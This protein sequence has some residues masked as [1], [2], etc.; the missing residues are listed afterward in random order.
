MAHILP[1]Y[2]SNLS[3]YSLRSEFFLS[4]WALAELSGGC[5]EGGIEEAHSWGRGRVWGTPAGTLGL[6]A[7]GSGGPDHL[8]DLVVRRRESSIRA[9]GWGFWDG[10]QRLQQET[11]QLILCTVW[12]CPLF[13]TFIHI[14]NKLNEWQRVDSQSRCLFQSCWHWNVDSYKIFRYSN[15]SSPVHKQMTLMNLFFLVNP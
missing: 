1:W 12:Y 5:D 14:L 7:A 4:G 6:G 11:G 9:A 10:T 13:Y 3:D 2:N 8:S 15:Q